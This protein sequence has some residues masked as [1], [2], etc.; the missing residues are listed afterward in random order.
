MLPT[1]L[2]SQWKPRPLCWPVT[3]VVSRLWS[4][5]CLCRQTTGDSLWWPRVS[6]PPPITWSSRTP[7]ATPPPREVR[8]R[9]A[10]LVTRHLAVRHSV[11]G[12]LPAFHSKCC[13]FQWACWGL[14]PLQSI[15]S[16][17]PR[18]PARC[19]NAWSPPWRRGTQVKSAYLR[20]SSRSMASWCITFRI[21]ALCIH[22]SLNLLS[23][24]RQ[25]WFFGT[26]IAEDLSSSPSVFS[27]VCFLYWSDT[28]FH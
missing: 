6:S 21:V 25:S 23:D 15:S 12:R 16:I 24:L 1:L 26:S 5:C 7:T 18:P 28:W 8:A 19:L 14:W 20:Q 3:V 11:R 2:A 22:L 10:S 17:K 27:A 4:V 13:V 9:Q